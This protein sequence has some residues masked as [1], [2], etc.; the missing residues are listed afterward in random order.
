[1]IHFKT[2]I[3]SKSCIVYIYII[4]ILNICLILRQSCIAFRV[5]KSI[6]I[7]I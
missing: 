2:V 7:F 5:R 1:M 3:A 6:K 4:F